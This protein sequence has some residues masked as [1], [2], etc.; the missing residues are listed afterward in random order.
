MRG[1]F[2]AWWSRLAANGDLQLRKVY[3]PADGSKRS[4]HS[5][6]SQPGEN[7]RR[8]SVRKKTMSKLLTEVGGVPPPPPHPDD[9]LTCPFAGSPLPLPLSPS[10]RA[11]SPVTLPAGLRVPLALW[12]RLMVGRKSEG[13]VGPG[14]VQDWRVRVRTRGM[15]RVGMMGPPWRLPLPQPPWARA[16]HQPTNGLGRGSP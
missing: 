15:D 2:A 1:R 4:R 12:H 10:L 14:L 6:R 11:S 3:G 13:A 5:G 8:V 7:D 9:C 16:L